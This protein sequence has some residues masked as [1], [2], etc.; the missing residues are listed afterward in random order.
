[1]FR[2]T[3]LVGSRVQVYFWTRLKSISLPII[4]SVDHRH[5]QPYQNVRVFVLTHPFAVNPLGWFQM[6]S[7]DACFPNYSGISC[8]VLICE[9]PL[10]RLARSRV[11][12]SL[13]IYSREGTLLGVPCSHDYETVHKA[14]GAAQSHGS[15]GL[16]P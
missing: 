10:L 16:A 15:M 8:L 9:R 6:Q 4:V 13:C 14:I 7:S 3:W 1:M 11:T 5:Q 2:R 12:A